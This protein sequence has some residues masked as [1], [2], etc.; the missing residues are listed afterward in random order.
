MKFKEII[1][2]DIVDFPSIK[3]L[4]QGFIHQNR[5]DIPVYGGRIKEEPIG[6]VCDNI[7]GAKY[8][9]NC[10]AWICILA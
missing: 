8:F 4:T 9:E 6:Y 1:L 10:L 2:K 7:E 3:G 5:G